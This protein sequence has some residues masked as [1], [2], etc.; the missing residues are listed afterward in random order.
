MTLAEKAGVTLAE[1]INDGIIA[2]DFERAYINGLTDKQ[3]EMYN[4]KKFVHLYDSIFEGTHEDGLA[5]LNQFCLKHGY[6]PRKNK[7]SV[8]KILQEPRRFHEFPN[9]H[10]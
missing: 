4:V 9:F 8:T 6:K 3:K 5:A 2:T 10:E 7:T 1:F